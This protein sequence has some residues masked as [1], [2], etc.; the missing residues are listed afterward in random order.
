MCVDSSA[1]TRFPFS[2]VVRFLLP[3]LMQKTPDA[4]EE[5]EP[6]AVAVASGK[7]IE[8]KLIPFESCDVKGYRVYAGLQVQV[9]HL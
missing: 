1:V 3:F 5:E 2:A 7:A 4:Q 8:T 9:M 6:P